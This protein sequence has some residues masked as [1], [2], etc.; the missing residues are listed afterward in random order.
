MQSFLAWE[1][2]QIQSQWIDGF[3]TPRL[4]NLATYYNNNCL[5]VMASG[6]VNP[7]LSSTAK[8]GT[9]VRSDTYSVTFATQFSNKPSIALAITGFDLS[10]SI[11]SVTATVSASSCTGFSYTISVASGASINAIQVSWIAVD[12]KN[13]P[14]RI[15]VP[16]VI[17]YKNATTSNLPT[18]YNT[19]GSRSWS[20]TITHGAGFNS[21]QTLPIISGFSF[22]VS[23]STTTQMQITVSITPIDGNGYTLVISTASDTVL[24]TAVAQAI[25]F[26][27]SAI[28]G[29]SNNIASTSGQG[30]LSSTSKDSYSYGAF[31]CNTFAVNF[32]AYSTISYK[33]GQVNLKSSLSPTTSGGVL[34]SESQASTQ[35][36]QLNG[37]EIGFC[38]PRNW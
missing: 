2:P 21:I 13:V 8:S 25:S 3:L 7:T 20:T 6:V 37:F 27:T 19:G 22:D 5:A 30:I 18:T 28:T 33:K 38:N 9:S 23:K 17:D 14:V 24:Y 32:W 4:A 36:Q 16:F 35:L 12:K 31:S 34:L 11:V 1:G 26:D 15:P 10:T 29:S